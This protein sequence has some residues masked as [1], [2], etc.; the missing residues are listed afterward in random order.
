MQ[1]CDAGG[2]TYDADIITNG[3]LLDADTCAELAAR[4]VTLAQVGLDGPPDVHDRMRPLVNGKGTFSTILRN[5]HHAVEH[6]AVSLRVNI[7][8]GNFD[9]VEELFRL[10]AAE[11]FGGKLGVYAGQIV[12]VK[13]NPLA[14]AAGYCGCF[15]NREFAQ[16]SQSFMRLAAQ[17]GLAAPFL[18]SPTSAPCTAVRMNEL[19]VGS[20][21]ELYKCWNSVGNP[22]EVI[23]HI[24]DHKNLNSRLAKWL[25]DDPFSNDECRSC[26]ALPV[27]MGGC[28]HHAFDKLQYEIA[29]AAFVIPIGSKCAS[30][31][32]SPRAGALQGSRRSLTSPGAW[33]RGRATV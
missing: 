3:Y 13:D 31:L 12:G 5:L 9:R 22:G 25:A 27:C 17:Y 16:A 2:V 15:S 11:G 8:M 20:H 19:V 24:R 1:R 30:S 10:L 4:K 14:P 32:I 23:G 29:A 33:R 28:A 18:P 21:G 26:I 7:D 6:F